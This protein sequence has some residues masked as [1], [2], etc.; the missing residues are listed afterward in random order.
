[1]LLHEEKSIAKQNP[2]V[3]TGSK[4]SQ[5]DQLIKLKQRTKKAALASLSIAH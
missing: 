1:V 4:L 2:I 3:S 5:I